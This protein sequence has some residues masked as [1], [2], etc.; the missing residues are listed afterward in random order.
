[1]FSVA[2]ASVAMG[3]A[4][5]V[6]RAAASFVSATNVDDGVALAIERLLTDGQLP[7]A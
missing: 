5:E 3:Q 4:S 2:G 7:S 6:V 1:M